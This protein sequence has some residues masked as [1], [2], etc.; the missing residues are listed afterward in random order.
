M[1]TFNHCMFLNYCLVAGLRPRT[2][3]AERLAT[4]GILPLL[5]A[6]VLGSPGKREQLADYLRKLLVEGAMKENQSTPHN[7]DIVNAVR[8]LWFVIKNL[9]F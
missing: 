3:V 9:L 1:L 4:L 2:P 7:I 6:G 8:F 5:L